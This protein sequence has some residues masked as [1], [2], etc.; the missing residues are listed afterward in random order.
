MFKTLRN[1][2]L[3]GVCA[4]A[5]SAC[6]PTVQPGNVGIV[7]HTLG[8]GGVQQETV[9]SGYHFTGPGTHIIEYPTITR[10]YQ[11]THS[12]EEA[13]RN[14]EIAFS[15]STG[16]PLT[17]DVSVTVSVDPS[18]IPTIYKTRRLTFDQLLDGPI[19][20]YAR[21]AIS[22]QASQYPSDQLYTA[23]RQ[24]VIQKAT[25]QMQ[26]RFA[27]EGIEISDMQWIGSIRFPAS[28]QDAIKRK[29]EVEQETLIA[30]AELQKAEAQAKAQVARAQGTADSAVATAKGASEA[31]RIQGEAINSNPKVLQLEWIHKWNGALPVTTLGSNP[32]MMMNLPSN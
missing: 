20:S 17:A 12:A 27:K 29:T 5:L 15:D 18:K 7:V 11:W 8:G 26:D 21:T 25:K 16:L 23:K 28:V 9:A 3:I 24:E 4:A 32:T 13:G 19:R 30:V 10:T 31:L 22:E 6:G 1:F 14:E 2:C